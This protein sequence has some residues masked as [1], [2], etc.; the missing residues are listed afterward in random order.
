MS[1]FSV[2]LDRVMGE[3]ERIDGDEE[4]QPKLYLTC[5]GI[6]GLEN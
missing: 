6:T 2:V 5:N 3:R 1:L 4:N